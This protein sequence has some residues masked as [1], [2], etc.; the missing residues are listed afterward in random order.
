M[1]TPENNSTGV[2][3]RAYWRLLFAVIGLLDCSCFCYCYYYHNGYFGENNIVTSQKSRLSREEWQEHDVP[4]HSRARNREQLAKNKTEDKSCNAKT[5]SS[6]LQS[7]ARLSGIVWQ[8][9]V[10]S[11]TPDHG[12]GP[13]KPYRPRL[14]DT[15]GYKTYQT[16]L[17]I[18]V[19]F[20]IFCGIEMILRAKEARR[21]VFENQAIAALEEHIAA[22]VAK[23]YRRRNLLRGKGR[24]SHFTLRRPSEIGKLLPAPITTGTL[25]LNPYIPPFRRSTITEETIRTSFDT[26]ESK[27]HDNES[28]NDHVHHDNN[29]DYREDDDMDEEATNKRNILLFLRSRVKLWLPIGVTCL[30][31]LSLLPFQAYSRIFRIFFNQYSN[32]MASDV[33]IAESDLYCEFDCNH[34]CDADTAAQCYVE[35]LGEDTS[36][37]TLWI[38]ACWSRWTQICEDI[39]EYFMSEVWLK[40][41]LGGVFTKKAKMKAQKNLGNIFN[42]PK[43]IW[44]RV[45]RVI[46][47][48]K[49]M[50][51]AFPLARMVIKLQDQLVMGYYTLQKVKS[52]RTNREKRLQRPSLLL[53]DLRRIE[54]FHKVETTIAALPSHCNML[55]D[56]LTKEVSQFSAAAQNRLGFSSSTALAHTEEFL[57]KSRER[58]RQMTM[59]IRRL[60][61]QLRKSMTEFSS[62]EIYDNILRMS[63]GASKR[64]LFADNDYSQDGPEDEIEMDEIRRKDSLGSR[65]SHRSVKTSWYDF[66]H[67]Q[68][69]LSSREYLISPRSRF[70]VVWRITVTHCL[71]LELTRLAVSWYLSETFYLSISQV[72]GR[73]FVDCGSTKEDTRRKFKFITDIFEEWHVGLSKAVPLVPYPKDT[74]WILC[75][76]TSNFSKLLLLVGSAM[77]TFIDVVSFLDIFFW[78]FTGDL[79][80]STGIVVPK[81]FFGRC[82]LPGT[83]VQVIDHPTLPHVLPTLLAKFASIASELGWSRLVL[84]ACALCPAL[85]VELVLPLAS[86]FFRHY[87]ETNQVGRRGSN[88]NKESDILMTYAES[89]GYL[90]T[91]RSLILDKANNTAPRWFREDTKRWSETQSGSDNDDDDFDGDIGESVSRWPSLMR[92]GI[93]SPQGP[94]QQNISRDSSVRFSEALGMVETNDESDEA[95]SQQLLYS[96]SS[97]DFDIGLSLSSHDLDNL[98][99]VYK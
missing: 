23:V 58:G 35:T 55:L 10:F 93:L 2:R 24:F 11:F 98:N 57:E 43:L 40:Y 48:F 99:N 96:S 88:R 63:Q 70:S 74:L 29:E 5:R 30:F 69:L 31:W 36:W 15:H 73:L 28:S 33:C 45:G 59:Q 84:W 92:K 8:S 1:A 83:L 80:A 39:E 22:T 37:A 52:V 81:P 53:Q 97:N 77:E 3:M 56:T 21:I 49:W 90:P 75:T 17:L 13:N 71:L 20:G 47:I 87:E 72:I 41:I 54:S 66:L 91:R 82:I 38:T 14:E 25:K 18:H 12:K 51:F 61:A 50:R 42:R 46:K 86:Y 4:R 79:D 19:V 7:P 32:R 27:S 34:L 76:P 78:F 44:F 9:M 60:R 68:S 89:F 62:S 65:G 64:N 26:F 6:E 85:A 94:L 95:G 16:F 67:L